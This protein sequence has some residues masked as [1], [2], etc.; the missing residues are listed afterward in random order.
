MQLSATEYVVGF[1]FSSDHERIALIRK[2]KPE[3]QKGKLNG[4]GGRMQQDEAPVG[5]MVREFEEETGAITSIDQ[6]KMYAEIVGENWKVYFFVTTGDIYKLSSTTIEQVEVHMTSNVN[7]F[8]P[9][10]I[11]NLPW[12]VPLAL[13]HLQTKNPNYTIAGYVEL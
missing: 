13:N 4:I 3:W 8:N 9:E 10:V 12:L 5:T 1:M 7:I 2:N 6:W 11:D